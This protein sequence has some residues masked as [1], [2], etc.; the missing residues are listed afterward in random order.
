MRQEAVRSVGIF[1]VMEGGGWGAI[2]LS[3]GLTQGLLQVSFMPFA[4]SLNIRAKIN[5]ILPTDAYTQG[6]MQS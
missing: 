2:I 5:L 3:D 4:G 1:G 6:V